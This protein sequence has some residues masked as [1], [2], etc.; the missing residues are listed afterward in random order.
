MLRG[1]RRR[2]PAGHEVLLQGVDLCAGRYGFHS[3]GHEA[4]PVVTQDVVDPAWQ[5]LVA[6]AGHILALLGVLNDKEGTHMP[7]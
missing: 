4:G 5:G 1:N 7:C 3:L 6:V 2:V